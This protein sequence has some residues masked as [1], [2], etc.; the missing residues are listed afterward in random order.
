MLDWN[1]ESR[2]W[3]PAMDY[4]TGDVLL[5]LVA[6]NWT[7]V[8]VRPAPRQGRARLYNVT[9]ARGGEHLTLPVLDCP[10]VH[11]FADAAN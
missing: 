1:G 3:T 2:H 4:A 10:A 8:N 6:Q 7:I 11:H 9:M 5:S